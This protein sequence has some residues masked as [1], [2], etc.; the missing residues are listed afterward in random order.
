MSPDD[1]MQKLSGPAHPASSRHELRT[2]PKLGCQSRVVPTQEDG[3]RAPALPLP[4]VT[5][6]CFGHTS[7]SS[8][9]PSG[10]Q[11]LPEAG[12][13][14]ARLA[15]GASCLPG[16]GSSVSAHPVPSPRTHRVGA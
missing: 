11:E 10:H 5:S 1:P 14:A 7:C 9:A 6:M 4:D 16:S 3:P 12:R 13:G 15:V 2:E 8:M